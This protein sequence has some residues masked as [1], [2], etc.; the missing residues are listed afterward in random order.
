MI[1]HRFWSERAFRFQGSHRKPPQ[2]TLGNAPHP[3]PPPAT[4]VL[5]GRKRTLGDFWPK[6]EIYLKITEPNQPNTNNRLVK[7]WKQFLLLLV[8]I[9]SLVTE[10]IITDESAVVDMCR[11]TSRYISTQTACPPKKLSIILFLFG[12]GLLFHL[13]F[14]L[15]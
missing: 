10:K 4:R 1:N 3:P 13:V 11:Y 8:F 6:T 9:A 15:K 2:K 14:S 12:C 5:E 7:T